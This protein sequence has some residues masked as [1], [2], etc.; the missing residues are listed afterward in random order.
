[1]LATL[2]SAETMD[3]LR[4]YYDAIDRRRTEEALS[5]FAPEAT[6]QA[7]NEPAQPW[8]QGLQAM[9]R[10]LRGVA[11]TRHAIR[12]VVEGANGETA[13]ELDVTYLLKSGEEITLAG[14]VFAVIHDERFHHQS[15]YVDL[16]PVRDAIERGS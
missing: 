7:S 1:M 11:G 2:V 15:L 9:A 8:M 10:Q 6:V 4:R 13:Y 12:R 16:A 14:A 3:F 5:S